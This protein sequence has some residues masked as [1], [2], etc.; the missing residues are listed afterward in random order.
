MFS[1]L[2]DIH[3]CKE[4]QHGYELEQLWAGHTCYRICVYCTF[5]YENLAFLKWAVFVTKDFLE[6]VLNS[7][8]F[9]FYQVKHYIDS[10]LKFNENLNVRWGCFFLLPVK[11]RSKPRGLYFSNT[12]FE[13][14]IFGGLIFR[15]VYIRWEMC[16]T[17][18]IGLV[19]SEKVNKKSMC[20]RLD[21]SSHRCC[22]PDGILSAIL[23]NNVLQV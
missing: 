2:F 11:F 3:L 13:G 17:I 16:V 14:L 12:H 23:G 15:G 20:C 19:Y 8:I 7:C 10:C 5:V 18:P 1:L 22:T 21:I 6:R 9:F 4:C